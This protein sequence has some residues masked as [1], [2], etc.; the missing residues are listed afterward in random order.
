M[1]LSLSPKPNDPIGNH[2]RHTMYNIEPGHR[3]LRQ[4]AHDLD[5]YHINAHTSELDT[6]AR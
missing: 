5:S 1:F 2:P 4:D 6:G 3:M